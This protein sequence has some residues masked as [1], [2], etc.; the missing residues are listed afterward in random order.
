MNG[1]NN[2]S[3][4]DAPV[5]GDD[6]PKGSFEKGEEGFLVLTKIG[7]YSIAKEILE[8]IYC[9]AE[10]KMAYVFHSIR[11]K[12]IKTCVISKEHA[13]VVDDEEF[14]KQK[15]EPVR[16]FMIDNNGKF[17]EIDDS[18]FYYPKTD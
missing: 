13:K 7:A 2:G 10:Y 9:C 5:R 14:N 6:F 1:D 15:E 16:N 4:F 8:D 12:E 18:F 17:T 3:G 11:D